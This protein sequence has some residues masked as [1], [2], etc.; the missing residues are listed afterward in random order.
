MAT[1]DF[2]IPMLNEESVLARTVE[3][4]RASLRENLP[5]HRW[6][7]VLA[8]N[9]ST[10]GTL[11]IAKAI[12][13]QHPQEVAFL[14]LP[15]R[16]R[17]RAL[18]KAWLES[19][20]DVLAYMDVDLSTDLS[21]IPALV[22]AIADEGYDV[23]TGSRLAGASRTTRSFKR[24]LTSRVYNLLIKLLFRTRFSD[25]QCGF[26][27]LSRQAARELVPR[28]KNE[29]WFF[30]TELLILAEKGGYRLKDI[31]VRWVEDPD[32]RVKL[33]KTITE[34]L[35]GLLRLRFSRIPKRES[36]QP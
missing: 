25:A 10:D 6:R 18:R 13:G 2:V 16:G 23:A 5:Q 33:V 3:T 15:E 26:K 14:H 21:A 31:P 1:V 11:A 30:D 20:S 28:I 22:S 29:E 8:D 24:E 36:G 34:D 27:A 9:G 19:D 4:L 35:R 7:I 17:G 12:A 32:T